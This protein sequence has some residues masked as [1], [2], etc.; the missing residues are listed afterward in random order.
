MI[1]LCVARVKEIPYISGIIGLGNK[2]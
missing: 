2:Y 1:L